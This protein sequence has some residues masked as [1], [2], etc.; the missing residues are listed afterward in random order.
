MISCG[1]DSDGGLLAVGKARVVTARKR[2]QCSDCGEWISNGDIMYMQSM[3]DFD[4]G[5]AAP[6][7]YMCERCGDLIESLA[8]AGYCFTYGNVLGQW[9]E[10]Q[11]DHSPQPWDFMKNSSVKA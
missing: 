3:Y 10:Y 2:R 6:P 7:L 9:R 5:L 1:C 11:Y 8:E 4:K